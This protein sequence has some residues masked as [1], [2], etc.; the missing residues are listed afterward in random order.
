MS[1][2]KHSVTLFGFGTSYMR[3]EATTE[4]I[5]KKTK[6]LGADGFEIVAPQMVEGHPCPDEEWMKRFTDLYQKYELQPVCYSI[7]VDNGKNKGRF[8]TEDE[9]MIYTINEMEY[10]KRMGFQVV[11]SQD[12]LQPET[13]E[14]LLPY[15]EELDVHLAIELHGP[16]SPSTPVFEKYAEL[17]EKKNTSSLGVVMDFSSFTSGASP[18]VLNRYPDSVC[19]KDL[20]NEIR[21]LYATTDIPEEELL[22][23]LRAKGGDEADV[24]IAKTDLFTGLDKSGK[25]GTIYYRTKPDYDGFRKLLKYSKYM[26]AKYWY[27]DE[28]LVCDDINNAEFLRI[29]KEEGYEGFIASEYEGSKF[30][31]SIDESTQ[32]ARHIRMLDNLWETV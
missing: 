25:M 5:L 23:Q 10:A 11:R 27:V 15:A 12:A 9:R 7:Y 18:I 32:I 30:D 21:H 28:N 26:H 4:D 8:L 19:H 1:K 6:E 20:L 3:G 31:S 22:E 17:F 14:K 29:M 24:M 13:M 16:Y 2:L